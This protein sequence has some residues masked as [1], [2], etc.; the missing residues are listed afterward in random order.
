MCVLSIKVPIR[1][2]FGNLFNDPRLDLNIFQGKQ[3]WYFSLWWDSCCR[4]RFWEA[5]LFVWDTLLL[6]FL[7]SLFTWWC[8]LPISASTCKFSFLRTS[9]YFLDL[10]VLFLS[11]F[12]FFPFSLF[13]RLIFQYEIPFLYPDCIFILFISEIPIHF[14][15]YKQLDAIHVYKLIN[16]FLWLSKFVAHS[17]CDWDAVQH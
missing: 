1:K 6:L 4:V 3:P 5:F 14:H 13:A 8:S 10:S 9:W 16:H 15:F 17:V 11:S 12:I 7:S 2:K